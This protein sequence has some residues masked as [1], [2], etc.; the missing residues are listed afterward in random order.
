MQ[1][2]FADA[3]PIAADVARGVT[4]LFCR[5]DLFGFCEVPLPNGRRADIMAI[6][7]KGLLTIVEIKVAKADLVGD[8]KWLDYLDYCDR[9][10]WAVPPDLA[11]ILDGERYLPGEA[12]LIVADRYD[13][14]VVR[15]AAH[16]PMAPARRKAELLRFA[17]RAAR[18]LAT[19]MDPTLGEGR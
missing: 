13:A 4:R 3:A 9:F 5:Q 2:C 19:Q 10:F 1:P 17:R 11:V 8:C 12:G 18:R 6:D 14:A 7:A 16:R 15:D